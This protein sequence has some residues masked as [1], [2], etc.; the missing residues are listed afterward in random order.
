MSSGSSGDVHGLL[1]SDLS[2]VCEDKATMVL[3]YAGPDPIHPRWH[4]LPLGICRSCDLSLAQIRGD[5]HDAI[6][7]IRLHKGALRKDALEL[8]DDHAAVRILTK[9]ERKVTERVAAVEV[10]DVKK[11]ARIDDREN[12]PR[13]WKLY[14]RIVC[15]ARAKASKANKLAK[16][17][18]SRCSYS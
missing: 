16:D 3:S 1:P 11:L 5:E 6:N 14:H 17:S 8:G 18:H 4:E 9:H 2:C 13:K 7:A 12:V 10:G 15:K